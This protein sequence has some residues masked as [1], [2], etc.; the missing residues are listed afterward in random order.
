KRR[1]NR[2]MVWSLLSWAAGVRSGAFVSSIETVPGPRRLRAVA[3]H[4]R[5]WRAPVGRGLGR[6]T[7][8]KG[9]NGRVCSPPGPAPISHP[10]SYSKGG[11]MHAT[12]TRYTAITYA[13]MRFMLGA[14]FICH[15]A[16]KLFGAFGGPPADRPLMIAGAVIELL[17]GVLVAMGLMT[18]P[19][20][21]LASGEMAV[22]YVMA[23]APKG[24][25]PIANGGE[26]AVLYCFAFLLLSAYGG[27]LYSLD[28]VVRRAASLANA[29]D[30]A[31]EMAV[32]RE[33]SVGRHVT[34]TAPR[35]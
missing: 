4:P 18:R 20:A 3:F 16:Q 19:A 33:A 10:S 15:G 28:T 14:L 30:A 32:A 6:R 17:A 8:R 12:P 21:F 2:F 9:W 29:D 27:G 23:H 5:R 34:A 22:A 25:W 26:T 7:S 13:L 35:V 31:A 24:V 1:E 11:A